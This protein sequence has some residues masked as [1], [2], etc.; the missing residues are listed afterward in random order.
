MKE[1]E[2]KVSRWF[3]AHYSVISRRQARALGLTISEID[4]RVRED[5]WRT[6]YKGVY[7]LSGTATSTISYLQAAVLVG[8]TGCAV[9][10]QSAAW[11]W[12]MSDTPCEVPTITVP[13]G[14][15]VR[16]AGVRAFR[17][18]HPVTRVSV[19][20]LPCTDA[21]S[22]IVDFA[23]ELGGAELD[24]LVDTALARRLVRLDSL[25]SAVLGPG[26]RR[27]CGRLDLA[28]RLKQRGVTGS[29]HPSALES[30]MARL[31]LQYDLPVPKAEVVWGPDRRY[32]LDFAYP[33]LK[34]AIEV[35]GWATHFSPEQQRYDHRRA[36]ELIK[37]GWTILRYSWWEVT[38]ESERVASEIA[39]TYSR[40]REASR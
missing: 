8:G 19:R 17:S 1:T 22:T 27:H 35:D 36:N 40:L 26:L 39:A 2:A 34:L 29:P 6:L 24:G 38:N 20:R 7:Q 33:A 16:M 14:R 15:R 11:L 21:I 4:R 5:R 25:T 9:S 30:R 32:R 18:R 31:M 23:S 12:G 3:E 37:A 13:G 28:E 10:H